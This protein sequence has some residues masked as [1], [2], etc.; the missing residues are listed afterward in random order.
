MAEKKTTLPKTVEDLEAITVIPTTEATRS[1]AGFMNRHVKAENFEGITEE[2]AWLV[3]GAHRVWQSSDE[4]AE[5]KDALKKANEEER[6]AKAAARAE[7]KAEREAKAAEKKA[8][9]ERKAAEKAAKEAAEADSDSDL[10]DEAPA[11]GDGE[12]PTRKRRRPR[13]STGESADSI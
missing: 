8:E 6:E 2:Q 7:A 5:E 9:Q 10:D 11:E 13:P 12:I 3:I 4:R 1:F